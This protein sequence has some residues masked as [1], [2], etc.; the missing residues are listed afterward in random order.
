MPQRI[1]LRL[2]FDPIREKRLRGAEMHIVAPLIVQDQEN[3]ADAGVLFAELLADGPK[4]NAR[5]FLHR[6]AVSAGA[7]GWKAD[8]AR[9]A[10]LGELQTGRIA[11]SQVLGFALAA[12]AVD[13]PDRMKHVLRGQRACGC[14]YG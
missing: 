12:I 3:F 1:V 11:R 5:G 9:S 7:D 10:L 2:L 8:A 6:I 13:R 4:R 14:R